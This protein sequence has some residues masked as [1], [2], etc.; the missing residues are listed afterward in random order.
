MRII[1]N[2]DRTSIRSVIKL[3]PPK[4]VVRIFALTLFVAIVWCI[5]YN[6]T[7]IASWN[8]PVSYYWDAWWN[9]ATIK[10]YQE[11]ELSP[12]S[13]MTVR[14]LNAPFSANWNDYPTSE[15]MLPYFIGIAARLF[16]L[17]PA[18]NLAGI[19]ASILA[20]LGFYITC[21]IL[22]YQ[23]MFAFAIAASFAFSHYI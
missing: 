5:S 6:R 7:T 19:M 12:F 21:R 22:R 14:S 18:S 20:A 1:N 11:G 16:G 4:E 15:K 9:M 3:I 23:W 17:I 2:L 13:W 8:V 10:A